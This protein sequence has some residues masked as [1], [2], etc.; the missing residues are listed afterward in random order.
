VKTHDIIH[1]GIVCE[2]LW[3]TTKDKECVNKD[4]YLF[5]ISNDHNNMLICRN[6][7]NYIV[8]SD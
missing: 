3:L 6:H 2:F 4:E 5:N 1:Y 7:Y 8:G